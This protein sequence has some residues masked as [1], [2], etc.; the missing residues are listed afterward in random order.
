MSSWNV[1]C[2]TQVR[3]QLWTKMKVW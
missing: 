3:I 2:L 1:I